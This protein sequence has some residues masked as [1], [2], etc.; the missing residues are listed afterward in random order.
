MATALATPT[1][2]A[3]IVSSVPERSDF[4]AS[5]GAMVGAR[6]DSDGS[7]V[8]RERDGMSGYEKLRNLKSKVKQIHRRIL[9][10]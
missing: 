8:Y 5:V 4:G 10:I 7:K 2:T 6:V 1:M 9:T 3:G